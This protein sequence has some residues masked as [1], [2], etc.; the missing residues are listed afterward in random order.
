MR[1]FHI[2]EPGNEASVTHTVFALM[3]SC[4]SR[5]W[6]CVM[7]EAVRGEEVGVGVKS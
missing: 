7:V 1:N 3:S 4:C 5:V 6:A 2:R